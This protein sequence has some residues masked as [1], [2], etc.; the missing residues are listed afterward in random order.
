MSQQKHP[1]SFRTFESFR[2]DLN[3]L[4]STPLHEQ[5]QRDRQVR[6]T[7]PLT[8]AWRGCVGL[9]ALFRNAEHAVNH[10][11]LMLMPNDHMTWLVL[12]DVPIGH[13]PGS[14][15]MN[16]R[17]VNFA[18][19]T[20]AVLR[21]GMPAIDFTVTNY[22]EAPHDSWDFKFRPFETFKQP[23][24]YNEVEALEKLGFAPETMLPLLTAEVKAA[25]DTLHSGHNS[26]EFAV[27]N[28]LSEAMTK[29]AFGAKDHSGRPVRP[30]WAKVRPK[31][32]TPS[33]VEPAYKWFPQPYLGFPRDK[34][35]QLFMA[36]TEARPEGSAIM[37]SKC[38]EH[39]DARVFE[40]RA[41]PLHVTVFE[42][43][44]FVADCPVCRQRHKW[45]LDD[46]IPGR[47]VRHFPIAFKD[48]MTRDL[49][50][51]LPLRSVGKSVYCGALQYAYERDAAN[52]PDAVTR[53]AEDL[54]PHRFL[55]DETGEKYLVYLP[56]W[57]RIVARQGQ[58]LEP[59]EIWG[60]G[61]H[62]N[63]SAAW[64]SQDRVAKWAQLD[65]VCGG[66]QYVGLFQQVWFQHQGVLGN[67][68]HDE[69]PGQ[70][71]FPAELVSLAVHVVEPLGIWW[72]ICPQEKFMDVALGALVFPPLRV[73]QWDKLQFSL[74][75]DVAMNAGI[76]DDRFDP[77]VGRGELGRKKRKVAA[78]K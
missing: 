63:P 67:K 14:E 13:F 23:P 40:R 21:H 74:P 32:I 31:T 57:S 30:S 38:R 60:Y 59:G 44:D 77:R 5:W 33:T 2:K 51:G 46:I 17:D 24:S 28:K 37:C 54:V 1:A 19:A 12:R 68:K 7:V 69:L 34:R 20:Q 76:T 16:R 3:A 64:A 71:L 15:S 9:A 8:E 66:Q 65:G 41:K 25:G 62:E 22:A 29:F 72:D 50:E 49:A 45:H 10:G 55:S 48:R 35:E 70:I 43:G 56:A 47:V 26:R 42:T 73:H 78:S 58:V 53:E 6:Q 61:L 18:T 39:I 52:L 4:P 27:L 11:P 75:G 36:A